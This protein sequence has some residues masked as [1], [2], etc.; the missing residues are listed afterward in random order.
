M[1]VDPNKPKTAAIAKGVAKR[2]RAY[3]SKLYSLMAGRFSKEELDQFKKNARA[4]AGG[5]TKSDL[6]K[7]KTAAELDD[8]S[9]DFDS[10]IDGEPDTGL[11]MALKVPANVAAQLAVIPN[12]ELAEDLHLTLC[13]LGDT[14]DY[15]TLQLAKMLV[16]IEDCVRW[17]APVSGVVSGVGRF[18][19]DDPEDPQ[20]VIYASVDAPGLSALRESIVR[21]LQGTASVDQTHGF[22]PHITLAYV[23]EEFPTPDLELGGIPVRFDSVCVYI[24][25][26]ETEIQL[27]GI[28]GPCCGGTCCTEGGQHELAELCSERHKARL[29][30]EIP[31]P[32]EFKE[33]LPEWIPYLPKPGRYVSPRYGEL[34][35]TKERNANF[36]KNFTAA[37]YQEKLP[38]DAEHELSLSGACGWLVAMR[39]NSDGSVDAKTDWTPRGKKL[40]EAGQFRYISP[41][42]FDKWTDPA[43]EK[44]YSDV[45][46]GGALTT[47]PFFKEK[48]LRPLLASEKGLSEGERDGETCNFV[49]LKNYNSEPA[50]TE[51]S[52]GN[53]MAVTKQQVDAAR[54]LVKAVEAKTKTCSEKELS[55]AKAI[56]AGADAA[57]AG[58]EKTFT[59]AELEAAKKEAAEAAKAEV[60]Q[61]KGKELSEAEKENK[62]LTERIDKLEKSGREMRFTEIAKEFAGNRNDHVDMLEFLATEGGGEDGDRFKKYV[63]NQKA[64]AEQARTG[65]IFAEVGSEG[66]G[67]STSPIDVLEAKARK[68]SEDSAG[69]L[70]FEAAL[71][72]VAK[73]EPQLYS[74]YVAEMRRSAN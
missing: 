48:S 18:D 73:L 59:E 29:F 15:T 64:L 26:N 28:D 9:V 63:Q 62:Q 57:A 13:V 7:G 55:D 46:Y 22:D 27:G 56:I 3:Q 65:K 60:E 54:E 66:A 44:E 39:Q 8:S 41:A 24:G 36:V 31:S 70:S 50:Y 69:K 1:A 10:A 52:E 4:H 35:I 6:R 33:K 71:G 74:E 72:E 43:T 42:F 58:G 61:A 16:A 34:V 21:R 40:V 45:A 2:T 67:G 17:N 51:L 32:L 23:A 20:D 12:G 49:E 53:T 5:K 68:M 14:S 30:V 37:V 47:R 38:L 19:G 11:W 25:D